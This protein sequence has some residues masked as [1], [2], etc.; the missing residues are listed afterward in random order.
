VPRGYIVG[1]IST[2]IR[3]VVL[4]LLVLAAA[5]VPVDRIVGDLVPKEARR[6]AE[7]QLDELF[8]PSVKNLPQVWGIDT[9][10]VDLDHA[11]LEE[12]YWFCY[13]NED[14]LARYYASGAF[15]PRHFATTRTLVFPVTADDRLLG[16]IRIQRNRR[17]DGGKIDDRHGKYTTAGG[18]T[19]T[20]V[21]TSALLQ[22]RPDHPGYVISYVH[23]DGEF[24]S[25]FYVTDSL[26]RIR[27]IDDTRDPTPTIELSK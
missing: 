16:T 19:S 11:V 17:P 26:G 20:D 25:Y 9:A 15:D 12:P 5:V 18:T 13:L 10:E 6:L 14:A 3:L 4:T 24:G 8:R 2:T 1:V 22:I 21:V 23:W 7:R 27:E